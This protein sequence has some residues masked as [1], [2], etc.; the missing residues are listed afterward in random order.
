MNSTKIAEKFMRENGISSLDGLTQPQ[1]K[2]LAKKLEASMQ[3]DNIYDADRASVLKQEF[4]DKGIMAL[5]TIITSEMM[6]NMGIGGVCLIGTKDQQEQ[7]RT[8]IMNTMDECLAL[9][10]M[11]MGIAYPLSIAMATL[12]KQAELQKLQEDI[13]E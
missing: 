1:A 7:S 5:D 12:E 6:M 11:M 13:S 8:I 9:Q 4:L 2:E 3:H 10:K